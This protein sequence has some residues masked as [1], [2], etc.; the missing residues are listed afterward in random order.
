MTDQN[1][2]PCTLE[3]KFVRLEPLR[4]NHANG[5]AEAASKIDWSLMLYPVRSRADVE[6][7]IDHYL[8]SEERDEEYA[9]AVVKKNEQ[10][11]IGSTA[12][13][14]VVSRH[15]RVEIGS[16]W[17]IPETRGTYVNPECKFLLLKHAFEDWEAVRVQLSTDARNTQSQRAILKLGASLEGRL[18]NYG[19]LPDGSLRDSLLYSITKDEWPDV[20][21]RLIA[22]IATF[23]DKERPSGS[24]E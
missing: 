8:K 16:T 17:Y 5:L 21:S 24:S 2:G 9:F 15:K 13:L 22:R 23:E 7:R 6:N 10:Q 12:Y 3:G 11:V 20:K 14:T 18:R 19:I 1:L 4:F